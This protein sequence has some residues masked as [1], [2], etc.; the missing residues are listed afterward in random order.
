MHDN[1]GSA[2]FGLRGDRFRFS[3]SDTAPFGEAIVRFPG[4]GRLIVDPAAPGAV[5]AVEV[6][7]LVES[8]ETLDRL[9]GSDGLGAIDAAVES[10]D[11]D[12][13]V[14]LAPTRD[15]AALCRLAFV[16]WY[17]RW[18]PLDVRDAEL[19]LDVATA[20]YAAG[21]IEEAYAMFTQHL[22]HLVD[23][24]TPFGGVGA[25]GA[26]SALQETLRAAI[27][28]LPPSLGRIAL[29]DTLRGTLHQDAL[30]ADLVSSGATRMLTDPRLVMLGAEPGERPSRN[31]GGWEKGSVDWVL[32]PR[33][34]VSSEENSVQW[35]EEDDIVV[36]RVA[37]HP[38]FLAEHG[39]GEHLADAASSLIMRF[40][41][42]GTGQVAAA[43]PLVWE[44]Q[45]GFFEG[46]LR[47]ERL[48][49][50][51]PL[52]S[53]RAEPTSAQISKPS[54]VGMEVTLRAA[55]RHSVWSLVSSREAHAFRVL[56]EKPPSP[57]I[58]ADHARLAVRLFDEADS[59]DSRRLMETWRAGLM[60][61]EFGAPTLSMA[62]TSGQVVPDVA[63]SVAR[64]LLSEVALAR[65]TLAER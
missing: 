56:G 60:S 65:R 21:E 42:R 27:W 3:W 18:T 51:L 17:A 22:D 4:D 64:P 38:S 7:D 9:F 28:S 32:V 59:G 36:C 33:G 15:A 53:L 11:L 44:D 26:R 55:W 49:H 50:G 54:V 58:T 37:P 19:Q 20:A 14:V 63:A 52:D 6:G 16:R 1:T 41:D 48:P 30:E 31:A 24:S 47:L 2:T 8:R 25:P 46:S 5:L 10:M 29:E 57:V 23:L 45:R 61:P 40:V 43:I 62:H 12:A 34:V 35:R 39:L 13:P